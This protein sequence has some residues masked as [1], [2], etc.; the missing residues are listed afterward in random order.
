MTEVEGGKRHRF[1]FHEDDRRFVGPE[2]IVWVSPRYLKFNGKRLA[3]ID[4]TRMKMS[5]PALADGARLGSHSYQFS[6]DF[7]WA[8][9]QREASDGEGL[10]LVPVE[11]PKEP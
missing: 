7:R 10:F 3:L 2:C 1:G 11:M 8:L 4:V 5:F 6:S 9:F